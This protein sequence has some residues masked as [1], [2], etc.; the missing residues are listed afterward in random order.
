M[1]IH[2]GDGMASGSL[3]RLS[4]FPSSPGGG[5]PA[6][7]W[8]GDVLPAPAVMQRIAAEVGFSE[9]AFVAPAKGR[10]RTVRYYSPE[11]EVSFCGHATIA[12]DVVLG[13]A[14]GDGVYRLATAVGEVPV[15]VRT[16]DGIR[17]ASLTSVEPKHTR[18]PDALVGEALSAFGWKSSDLDGS[19]PPVRAYAGAWHLV[20]AVA[21]AH[22][23]AELN[24]DFDWTEGTDASRRSHHA[25]TGMAGAFRRF[26]LPQSVS[27]RRRGRR[28]GHG[29]GGRRTGRIP[30]RSQTRRR[31]HY[32]SHPP[33]RSDGPSEPAH[34]GD[35]CYRWDYRDRNGGAARD[36]LSLA[37]S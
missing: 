10:E 9:T 32:P 30:A 35:S 33:G 22:R 13:E 25:A 23:L 28:P 37:V 34:G 5:N 19:I 21:D 12:A 7:V 26:S 15:T 4:A 3:Q 2:E 29:R 16:R 17:E 36:G 14:E 20:L 24:Y 18:A 11:A 31:A 8:I 1:N 27:G 6:G